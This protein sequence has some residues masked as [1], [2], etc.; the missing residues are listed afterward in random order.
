[1]KAWSSFVLN[2]GKNFSAGSSRLTR[3]ELLPTGRIGTRTFF[4]FSIAIAGS[5]LQATSR[6]HG[7]EKSPFVNRAG[8]KGSRTSTN[9][10]T[11]NDG[12]GANPSA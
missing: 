5:V 4:G 7:T 11:R 3:A 8:K 6:R 9:T 1:M 10:S 12:I 2:L